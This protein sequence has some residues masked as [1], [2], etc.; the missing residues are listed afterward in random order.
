MYGTNAKMILSGL[1]GSQDLCSSPLSPGSSR[2]T[3]CSNSVRILTTWTQATC[4]S[5]H[6]RHLGVACAITTPGSPS[7]RNIEIYLGL[8]SNASFTESETSSGHFTFGQSTSSS[9]PYKKDRRILRSGL[10]LPSGHLI[11]P[12]MQYVP[13]ISTDFDQSNSTTNIFGSSTSTNASLGTSTSTI[14]TLGSSTTTNA[15]LGASIFSTGTLDTSTASAGIALRVDGGSNTPMPAINT[16]SSSNAPMPSKGSDSV[17]AVVNPTMDTSS[18]DNTR[19]RREFPRTSLEVAAWA[20]HL[21]QQRTLP[22]D[23]GAL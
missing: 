19:R 5:F 21:H 8:G 17:A 14:N 16:V 9:C 23:G 2:S 13:I 7:H 15:S 22:T 3:G 4:P 18:G 1:H 6:Q 20:V 11:T 12:V 10:P